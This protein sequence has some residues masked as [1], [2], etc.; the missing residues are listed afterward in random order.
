MTNVDVPARDTP[1]IPT[2]TP[3]AGAPRLSFGQERI[4][5]TEQL[6]PG[7]AAYLV[8]ATVRLRGPFD[9]ELLR[10]AVDATAARHD[11]LRMRFTE[12][13]DGE[14]VVHVA[15]DVRVP[16]TVTAAPGEDDAREL[17]ATSVRT[18][19]D[20]GV[21]PL[22][23]V[24]VVRLGDE[25]H[26]VHLVM[27]H[28]VSDGWSLTLLLDEI[29]ATYGALRD[30]TPPPP[31]PA[32]SYLEYAA[33][34]RDRLDAPATGDGFA[35]W[36]S[37]L[38]GVPALELPTDRPRPAVQ[39]YAGATHRFAL[40]AD[41]TDGLRRLSRAHR[42]TLYMTLLTGLQAVLFRYSG[43][44]DFAIGS[45]V[46]GRVVPE[47]ENLVG[48]FVNTLALRADLSPVD[49]TPDTATAE[50]SFAT[51]LRR[52]RTTVVRA[53]AHQE[54]PF[55][56][57]VKELNVA[58]DVSRS[59]VFQVLFTLQNYAH[60]GTRWPEDLRAEGV[61]TDAANA[62]FD[63]SLYVGETVDG[64]RGMVVYNTDLFD[65]ATVRGLTAGLETLLRAA[66][67][68]PDLPV[69]DLDL[70]DADERDRM[71]ALGRPEQDGVVRV[72]GPATTL[73]ELIA[74]HVA[75]SPDAPAVV[76]GPD[77]LTY[78]EL[79]RRANQLAHWLRGRGVGPDRLVGVLLDQS[80]DLA[81]TLLGVL[82]AGGAYLPLD[83]EQP[84]ARLGLM[85]ADACPTVVLTSSDL[86]DRLP[87]EAATAHLDEIAAEVAAQPDTAP[88]TATTGGHLAY[89][90]Y[91]S[92]STGTPKGV[93]VAHRQVLHYLDGV[94]DRFAVVP[95]AR[96]G[97]MQSMSFDFS[98]TLFYLALATG[99][100]V[101]LLPRRCTGAELAERLRTARIDYLK[102]IPSHL[103]AL[104]ADA[105]PGE[106][107]PARA[108]VLG[109]EQSELDRVGPL[110]AVGPARVFNHYGPTEATVG[111]TTYE[112]TADG[113]ATGPV[114]IGRPLPYA[115]VYVL[116][117]RMRP[118]PVGVP[119][120]LYLGGDRLARGYLNRPDLTDERFVPDPYG[121]PGARLYRTGDLGRW[122]ADGQLVFLG[123]RDHQVKIR[124]YRVELGEIEAALRDCPGVRQA[125]VLLRDDRLV[126][127][128][129]AAPDV[130]APEP[131]AL[132]RRLA[133]RLPEHMA[134]S[135]WVC[136]DRLPL[137]EH[138][139]VDRRALPEPVDDG[140]TGERETPT[141]PVETLVADI[142]RAVLGVAV[143]G[144]TDDFFELGGHSLLATQV[145]ARLR[146]ELPDVVDGGTPVSVM[147]LFRHRTVRELALLVAG[148][149]P[150]GGG[151]LHE[152]TPPVPAAARVAT[153]V[154]VPYGG[155]SAVVYQPLADALPAGYRLLSV[156]MPGHDIGLA[157]DPAPIADVAAEVVAEIL[158][159]VSGPLI[160]YGHCGPGGAL[161]VEVARRLEAAGRDLEAVYL[162]AVFPFARPV[163]GLLGPLLR[164]RLAE[165]L[166]SDRIY[167]TWLQAQGTSVGSLAPD[168]V[169]FLIR[170]MRH[171]AEV[172]EEYFTELMRQRTGPLRAP[173][174]SVVGE[175]DRSTDFHEER[176]REWHFLSDRTALAVIDEAGHY[177]LKYRAAELAEIVT[178][179]HRHLTAP[180]PTGP[181]G[182]GAPP[183]AE[184]VPPPAAS[185]RP[186]GTEPAWQLAAVS[187]R[188]PDGP[189]GG[190]TGSATAPPP[191][192]RRFGL[193]AAGQ[194]VSGMGTALTTFAVPLWIYTQTGS[195]ARFALFAVLA[196]MPGLLVAPLA[197][198]VIDRFSRRRVLLSAC[199]AAGGGNA[200]MAVLVLTDLAEV[201]HFYPFTAWL[202]VSLAFQRLAFVS[203]VPQLVPKRFLGHANGLAQTAV[204]LTQFT[205]PLIA[206]ALLQAVGLRGILL[207][208]VAS[209]LF[210]IGVLAVVKFPRTLA[211]QRRE[212]IGA[213][214]VA[215]LRY[216]LRRREFRAMLAFFAALNFFLFPVLFLLSPLVLGFADLNEVARI[217]L[218]GGVG[219]ATGG[220]VMLLWGGPRKRRM[221]AVLFGTLGIAVAAVVTGLR[222]NL[223]VIGL[224]AFG[225]YLALAIVNGVYNTI[226]QTKVPPRVHGRVFALNQM[227]AQ[228]TL[229][230]GWGLVA[231]FAARVTEPMLLADGVLA[232]TVGA[233][234]GVGPGRGHGL[235]YVLFGVCI[236]VTA[237]VSLA[238]PVLSRFDDEVP[239]APP[240][241]L[242]GIEE[243]RARSAGAGDERVPVAAAGGK[244]D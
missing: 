75:A 62:R 241:D 145:V 118:V 194:I 159:R 24:L 94:A 26:L 17:V 148:D 66:V 28:I 207:I 158:D 150:G 133:D 19:F 77:T 110:A 213:E 37:T 109:G 224:G 30:G 13:A 20:L 86:R 100:A 119:G 98:V 198:A 139:K 70:L 48:L 243:R 65:A 45:P 143:V 216:A 58:R 227:V 3:P 202:S 130:A 76:F 123:R 7:T 152:L 71:L 242:V 131:A 90:I 25:E 215:G 153:L 11:S 171:D 162:G 234:I 124:G 60:G 138:G 39:S 56:R 238:T 165:R 226:I 83:P 233:V 132:R 236:A 151:L 63:L 8:H 27:H 18:P 181:P 125:A 6:T 154:C 55:E 196:V 108:L 122:R 137:Q 240:D 53:L 219:A 164:L 120:E 69:V 186:D 59:P 72:T 79:D 156:A 161:A 117:E 160:L 99:G 157:D 199:V 217:A 51:L 115:R 155:G 168:E 221:R 12:N 146:R 84:P 9:V 43:Q 170:A 85:L 49:A 42:A 47:S 111:V 183:R 140:P 2:A 190:N 176:F 147:D 93:A 235:L 208:D 210:A 113:P 32:T 187:H 206:V 81:A 105:E 149:G 193:V 23:R 179:V 50:P 212:S 128:L 200:V 182:P 57:L 87:A 96:Y 91:T 74:P 135:R 201:W 218:T 114:P 102:I 67:A 203:A 178:G 4:W 95:A 167:R 116:D 64:L 88:D 195:L 175:R 104:T 80:V 31:A 46:A 192:M 231:P 103:W 237:L 68:R 112:V 184:P 21:A 220:L 174:V 34:Q 166:R 15:P 244:V 126:A 89:V 127:Y 197:G 82:R 73:A 163:G 38:A 209:Y 16:V 204:G 29:A 211:L 97:L 232:G 223:M 191:S 185:P 44:R 228:S 52:T 41:L 33:W 144:A 10:G 239:D 101:H 35:Y 92:G 61:G 230:L 205:V 134:P 177:F 121:P 189:P 129:E 22:L 222:P 229:P 180:P 14:P 106:L 173:V 172:S 54:I 214:I 36:T 136:L 78:R 5:F 141:G 1:A 169:T 107:L 142:W 40:D 188:G 225:M